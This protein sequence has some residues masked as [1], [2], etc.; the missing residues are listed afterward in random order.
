[1]LADFWKDLARHMTGPSKSRREQLVEARTK[2]ER[3]LEILRSGPVRRGQLSSPDFQ[4]LIADL[5][6]VQA[7]IAAN[8]DRIDRLRGAR[9]RG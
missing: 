2:V 9:R 3:Q 8:L 7:G 4:P 5:E 6:E 1:M